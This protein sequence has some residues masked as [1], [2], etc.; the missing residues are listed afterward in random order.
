[1]LVL[2]DGTSAQASPCVGGGVATRACRSA[3][4][5][6]E[7]RRASGGSEHAY[8]RKQGRDSGV[9]DPQFA[10]VRP[11]PASLLG[12]RILLGDTERSTS[13]AMEQATE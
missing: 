6:V 11:G 2:G 3:E 8:R 13:D 4:H 7:G 12:G 10:Y 1:V 9:R 5:L